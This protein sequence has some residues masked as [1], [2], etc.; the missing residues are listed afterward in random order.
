V[1]NRPSLFVC[2]VALMTVGVT[3]AAE[4]GPASAPNTGPAA[5]G[6][7]CLERPALQDRYAYLRSLSFNLR[8]HAP[9]MAEYAAL[10]DQDDV[11]EDQIDAFLASTE[12]AERVVRH[13]HKLL[14]PNV[15]NVSVVSNE[16]RISEHSS[17]VW[18][19]SERATFYRGG[20]GLYD[21]IHCL[22][23]EAEFAEDGG[24][25]TYEDAEGQEREG[26]VPVTP[27]WAPEETIKVCA[28]DAQ[29]AIFSGNGTEC[30][31]R[32]GWSVKSCGCGPDLNYCYTDSINKTLTRAMTRDVDLRITR[33]VTEDIPYTE[34]FTG[35][36]GF[37]NG[38]MVHFLRYQA[39]F[40]DRVRLDPV[41]Y[42]VA[43][44][45]DLHFT[46]EETWVPV[47]LPEA[48]AGV[49]TST[50]YLLRFQTNRARA[51]RFYNAFLCRPFQPPV[52]GLPP[53]D[54]ESATEPDLQLRAG[55]KYCHAI[56]EPSAA[57][58]GRWPELGG[59]YADAQVFPAYREDCFTCALKN[60]CDDDC[61]R[62]YTTRSYTPEVN[63]YL[64]YLK[65]YV[66]RRPEHEVNIEQ[67]PSLLAM[68]GIVS[69]ELPTC[70]AR[71]AVEIAL[72]REL[73]PEE[74]SWAAELAL[75]FALNGFSYRELMKQI[76]TS[77]TY[78]RVR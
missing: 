73:L 15:D 44:L 59:G 2:V 43:Q 6:L 56:L 48:H 11:S 21:G 62:F 3:A 36:T 50:A 55:C 27:Y 22:D 39:E 20:T 29:D 69:H 71:T 16:N 45:P 46:D 53:A 33:A 17:G 47:Q 67:G 63:V 58:W 24:I 41:P 49:L 35:R 19:R 4:T 9:T 74:A 77:D 76:V 26:W 70:T 31:S 13:H 23:Q 60:D 54:D 66:F 14:W 38:P 10:D 65:A 5:D 28:F 68:Q 51:N 12:F 37:V 52:G 25:I 40:W 1:I 61:N 42:N 32:A 34:L 72:A 30:A 18:Y 7:M 8:G 64:G 78:R 57:H 75:N